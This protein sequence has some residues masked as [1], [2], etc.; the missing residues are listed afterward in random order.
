MWCV[1]YHHQKLGNFEISLH[2]NQT[3]VPCN[4]KSGKEIFNI[5]KIFQKENKNIGLKLLTSALGFSKLL[6]LLKVL[7]PIWQGFLYN[8]TISTQHSVR[9]SRLDRYATNGWIKKKKKVHFE[10]LVLL[11]RKLKQKNCISLRIQ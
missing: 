6:F 9:H 4:Q 8:C 1:T 7:K 10:H 5:Q 2:K 11:K 3:I